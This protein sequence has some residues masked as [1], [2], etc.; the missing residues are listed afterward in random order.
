MGAVLPVLPCSSH[1]R[2]VSR[3]VPPWALVSSWA[4]GGG[5]QKKHLALKSRMSALETVVL[6][7]CAGPLMGEAFVPG[8]SF[9]FLFSQG[10]ARPGAGRAEPASS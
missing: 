6:Q 1:K 7:V 2:G 8:A 4:R 9:I 5:E 10:A 3:R